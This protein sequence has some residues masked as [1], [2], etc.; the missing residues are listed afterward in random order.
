MA[1]HKVPEL[2]FFPGKNTP[3]KRYKPYFY[4]FQLREA[5]QGDDPEVVLC[6]SL[7]IASAIL[8]CTEN[9]ITPRIVCM[10]GTTLQ[11]TCVGLKIYMFRPITKKG[12]DDEKWFEEIVYYDIP[13]E[14][15]HYPYQ[16]KPTRDKIVK[17]LAQN[18]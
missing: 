17:T 15:R 3:I 12:Q 9:K 8:F 14:I 4:Q 2:I 5:K 18:S 16:H 10:D 7:G 13:E 11:T 6:H 1:D